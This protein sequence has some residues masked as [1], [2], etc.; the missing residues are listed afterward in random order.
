MSEG[1]APAMAVLELLGTAWSDDQLEFI[2]SPSPAIA[3]IAG[4][5]ALASVNVSPPTGIGRSS[6]NEPP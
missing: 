6:A 4:A 2:L 1:R 5:A 3:V